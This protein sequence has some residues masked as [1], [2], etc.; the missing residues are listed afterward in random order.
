MTRV[1]PYG[2]GALLVEVSSLEEVMALYPALLTAR[3]PGIGELVPAARTILVPVDT[4]RLSLR[5]AERWIT[6]VSASAPTPPADSPL[7][8]IDVVYDGEDLGE[9]AELTGR[10]RMSLIDFHTAAEW[11]V[12]F[13]GFAPGFA[14]LASPSA[15][16]DVP[17]RATARTRV[18]VGSVGLG[19][20]FS[21]VYPRAS[22][23]GWQLIGRTNA[24]LW[25]VDRVPP[26]LLS[27]GDRVRFRAVDTFVGLPADEVADHG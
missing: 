13:I 21:G 24:T 9:V 8:T 19:G 2:S 3:A 18:P 27:P 14:Y 1:L 7:V 15:T 22:P 12:A 5:A 6:G 23:G 4:S 11:R 17:R 16:L 20:Q 10:T 25:D 26:A